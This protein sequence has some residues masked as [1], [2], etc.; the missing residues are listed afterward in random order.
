MRP[1][2]RRRWAAAKEGIPSISRPRRWHPPRGPARRGGR[3]VRPD[4][5]SPSLRYTRPSV[6]STVFGLRNTAAGDRPVGIAPPAASLA[7]SATR[8]SV[9]GS[10]ERAGAVRSDAAPRTRPVST[11]APA[12]SRSKLSP[13][14]RSTSR[15]AC[16]LLSPPAL[17]GPEHEQAARLLEGCGQATEGSNRCAGWHDR[18]LQVAPRGSDDRPPSLDHPERSTTAH[19]AA[20]GARGRRQAAIASSR[21]PARAAAS[22][23]LPGPGQHAGVLKSGRCAAREQRPSTGP[24]PRYR[25]SASARIARLSSDHR[26]GRN[27][28]SS[29]LGDRALPPSRCLPLPWLRRRARPSRARQAATWARSSP[30]SLA[31]AFGSFEHRHAPVAGA[32]GPVACPELEVPELGEDRCQGRLVSTVLGQLAK[33]RAEVRSS[34]V[35][36]VVHQQQPAAGEASLCRPESASLCLQVLE[37]PPPDSISRI[38]ARRPAW[39]CD[40]ATAFIASARRAWMHR[41]CRRSDGRRRATGVTE[42]DRGPCPPISASS[43]APPPSQLHAVRPS[44]SWSASTHSR[45]TSTGRAASPLQTVGKSKEQRRRGS[46]VPALRSQH[47]PPTVGSL[48]RP[49]PGL[50]RADRP[51]GARVRR[52][53]RSREACARGRAWP[54]H[55]ASATALRSLIGVH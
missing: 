38:S 34:P 27:A 14:R 53:R 25:S 23:S 54:T 36:L 21:W 29:L 12:P 51:A 5:G 30:E 39:S 2:L 41:R 45:R 1:S 10:P 6:A 22:T 48:A 55:R 13:G 7:T 32:T 20:L 35:E 3:R 19:R 9:D 26:C 8:L 44:A 24:P 52:A 17:D 47:A 42:S 28:S 31:R 40:R 37:R 16:P 11:K 43:R 4:P 15:L 50:E 49:V 33:D 18:T 46:P